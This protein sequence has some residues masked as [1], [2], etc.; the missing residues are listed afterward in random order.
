MPA[1]VGGFGNYLLPLHIG[2]PDMAFPRLNNV[3]F[4]LLPPSLILLLLSSLVEN[5]AGTGWTVYPPLA[6]I[7]SHSGG[8]VDLAIFSL[9]LAG[10]SSLLGAINFISTTLNMRTQGMNYHT[11]P[12]HYPLIKRTNNFFFC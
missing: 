2:A 5:G 8:A 11:L 6:A 9:H 1:L 10:V 3:S 12:L 7:Q 4:W